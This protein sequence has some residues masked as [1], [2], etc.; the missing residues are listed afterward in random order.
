MAPKLFKLPSPKP[1]TNKLVPAP[2]S[3]STTSKIGFHKKSLF[4]P[5][6]FFFGVFETLLIAPWLKKRRPAPF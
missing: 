1:E 3:L 2:F 4:L 5:F 6:F